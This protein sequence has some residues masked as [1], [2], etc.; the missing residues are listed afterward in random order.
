MGKRIVIIA[1]EGNNMIGIIGLAFKSKI[2]TSESL[3]PPEMQKWTTLRQYMYGH[4]L[5]CKRNQYE[6]R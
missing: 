4:C 3:M 5:W 6:F 2:L 1:A